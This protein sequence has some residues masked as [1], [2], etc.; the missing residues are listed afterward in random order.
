VRVYKIVNTKTG[1]F[2]S[3]STCPSWDESGKVWRK[4]AHVVS[5]LATIMRENFR[6]LRPED[7]LPGSWKV[8]EYDIIET[9]SMSAAEFLKKYSSRYRENAS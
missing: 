4:R 3:G 8:V 6:D 9:G 2:S 1:L 5:H 7:A